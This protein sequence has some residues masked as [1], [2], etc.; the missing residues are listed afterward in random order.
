VPDAVLYGEVWE[1]ASH[2]VAYGIRKHYYLGDELD[3]VMNYPLRTG[4]IEYLRYGKTSPL[5][6]GIGTLTPIIVVL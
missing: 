5:F 2:K 3:G 1:D 4:L 6:Y